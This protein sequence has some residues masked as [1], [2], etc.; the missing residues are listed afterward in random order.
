MRLAGQICCACKIG[1]PP[2]HTGRETYCARCQPVHRVYMQF[3]RHV[4]WHVTFTDEVQHK[5]LPRTLTYTDPAKITELAR[6]G[7]HPMNL[8]GRQALDMGI[9]KGRGGVTLK[10][11]PEQY[12]K[13]KR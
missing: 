1:L 10:L 9:S 6:R 5:P 7:G 12:A 2:P 11:T 8:E 13:L 4:D 3:V